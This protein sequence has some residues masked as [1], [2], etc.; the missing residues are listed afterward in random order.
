MRP[1]GRV[2]FKREEALRS[3]DLVV[4]TLKLKKRVAA[5]KTFPLIVLIVAS[6]FLIALPVWLFA[7]E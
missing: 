6:T 4:Q 2:G 5:F 1:A 7:S 3:V